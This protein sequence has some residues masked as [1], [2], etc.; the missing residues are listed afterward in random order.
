MTPFF[1]GTICT[2]PPASAMSDSH[3][4]MSA[5]ASHS[6]IAALLECVPHAGPPTGTAL[7][8][9][10]VLVSLA[11]FAP[12]AP[13]AQQSPPAEAAMAVVAA[14][15]CIEQPL[16]DAVVAAAPCAAQSPAD[17]VVAAAPCIAQEAASCAAVLPAFAPFDM[18]GHCPAF[19][20]AV[21][22]AP[23]IAQ[24]DAFAA[25]VPWVPQ[26]AAIS[27]VQFAAI[28]AEQAAC[29][30]AVV[31]VALLV[32]LPQAS[33]NAAEAPTTSTANT[34]HMSRVCFMTHLQGRDVPAPGVGAAS[35]VVS[36]PLRESLSSGR[37]WCVT[38][39][40]KGPRAPTLHAAR[41]DGR[42]PRGMPSERPLLDRAVA[43]AP[44]ASAPDRPLTNGH[45][46]PNVRRSPQPTMPR[47]R[48]RSSATVA[49]T[50]LVLAGCAVVLFAGGEAWRLWN[51]DAGRLLLARHFGWGDPA[52][53]TQL[54]GRQVHRGLE[55]AGVPRDSLHESIPADGR[56]AVHWRVGLPP[57]ASALQ[58]N[59]AITRLVQQA[60]GEV[61]TGRESVGPH[62]EAL[63]TLLI[64]LPRRPTHEV[65]LVRAPR[66]RPAADEPPVH[67]PGRLALVLFGFGDDPEHAATDFRIAHP[68][69]VALVPGAPWSNAMFRAARAAQRELVLHLPLEP[70]NYPAVNPGPGTV[71]VTME[72]ARITGLVRRYL[73]TAGPV[74]AASNHM[75]SLAT[76]DMQVMTAVYRELHRRGVPFVHMQPAAG[77]VCRSLASDQG[78]VYGE[79][80]A[81]LD[82]EAR[83]SDTRALDARW[84]GVLAR[85]RESGRAIVYLRVT[86][87]SRRWLDS[88]LTPARLGGVSVV[89]L[90]SLLKK[91]AVL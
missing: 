85:A 18:Y 49:R 28:S 22:A 89:P 51:S 70:V 59:Y 50:L 73:D 69:A 36:V 2:L 78:V 80:D 47:R 55:A 81:V 9:P 53:I 66:A 61:L 45:V 71:L 38:N 4:I 6:A 82:A 1:S 10:A 8:T 5:H 40:Q 3:D 52:R 75:G 90:A 41:F 68:F 35:R 29:V 79:P 57:A 24:P 46:P 87:T 72:P 7:T 42:G 30:E 74:S 21:V 32:A 58:T 84:K 26:V 43:N 16:A 34:V 14:V 39:G 33:A 56:A 65:V 63:V 62:G 20:S 44:A 91:G 23:C 12:L 77:S 13:G 86:P 17:A 11:A 15:P 25:A 31:A 37:P 48:S 60:G 54:M 64:G 83:A 88:A 27:G 67:E 19:M 76:Q